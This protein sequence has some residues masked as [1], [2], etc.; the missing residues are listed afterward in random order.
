[1]SFGGPGTVLTR[2][3][4]A[5]CIRERMATP[6]GILCRGLD[7]MHE[8]IEDQD[9]A[10][11]AD[12]LLAVE[13]KPAPGGRL[14]VRCV[15][16]LCHLHQI[17][18]VPYGLQYHD[19]RTLRDVSAGSEVARGAKPMMLELPDSAN[20]FK[21]AP[22]DRIHQGSDIHILVDKVRRTVQAL[23]STCSLLA[24]TTPA[25][26]GEGIR[27]MARGGWGSVAGVEELGFIELEGHAEP[28]GFL[29]DPLEVAAACTA[30][31]EAWQGMHA[32]GILHRDVCW[33]LS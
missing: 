23:F 8:R 3:H 31:Q 16:T 22:L 18:P 33:Q 30:L 2:C 9:Q 27:R 11:L 24:C 17:S 4:V 26:Q 29:T 32:R 19:G 12:S 7:S 6:D 21:V 20:T 13:Y 5:P 14:L 25:C 1:M 10:T 28:V 15:D